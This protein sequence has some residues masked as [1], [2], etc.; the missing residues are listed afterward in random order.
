MKI[1]E[2]LSGNENNLKL[3]EQKMYYCERLDWPETCIQ[4]IDE[5]KRQRGISPQLLDKYITYYSKHQRYEQ[6]LAVID[7]WAAQF[8][9]GRKYLKAKIRALTQL[10]RG[11]D[12]S[13]LLKNYMIGKSSYDDLVFAASQYIQLNDTL[14]SAYYLS[15]LYQQDPEHDLVYE[16]YGYLLLDL[17][18]PDLGLTVLESYAANNPYDFY[19]HRN[20]SDIYMELNLFSEG[21]SI[22]KNFLDKDTVVYTIADLFQREQMWDSAHY[23]VDLIIDRDSLNRKARWKKANMYEA[24]GWLSVSLDQYDQLVYQNPDDSIARERASLV[25]RKIA[26]LQRLKFEA[27]KIPVPVIESIKLRKNN[28]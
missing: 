3:V 7:Q 8:N 20:L 12:A 9:A 4:A 15:K 24:R 16:Y 5:L 28:E 22:L 1:D 25:R 2:Q 18:Y 10:G 13:V 14:F 6:L 17:G 23:Y 26:Y 27:N 21:R 11:E 19:F